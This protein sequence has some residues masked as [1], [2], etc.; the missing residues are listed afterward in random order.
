M[1]EIHGYILAGGMSQRFGTDKARV[2]LNGEQLIERAVRFLD[3]LGLP[4]TIVANHKERFSDLE[5]DVIE[6]QPPGHGPLGGLAAALEHCPPSAWAFLICC[7]LKTLSPTW[8]EVLRAELSSSVDAV[9]FRGQAWQPFV[10]LYNPA[11]L[12][13]I[14]TQLEDGELSLQKLL[15][16]ASTQPVSLPSDWLSPPSINTPEDLD[17]LRSQEPSHEHRT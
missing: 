3:E 1:A 2:C 13:T 12:S 7:D 16:K 6:D 5:Q 10:A 11:L 8:L 14:R 9:A 17:S 4:I 15:D